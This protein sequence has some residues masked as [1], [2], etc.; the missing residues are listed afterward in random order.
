MSE[1]ETLTQRV[2]VL[3]QQV[4]VIPQI[5]KLVTQLSD[6]LTEAQ[7]K[8]ATASRIPG[9]RNNRDVDIDPKL[10]VQAYKAYHSRGERQKALQ[11][12]LN[13]PQSK[14]RGVL[15]WSEPH[16]FNYLDQ[17]ELREYYTGV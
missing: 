11:R 15:A 17:H 16:F 5:M 14:L 10:A 1:I 12:R 7:A 2:A 9:E 8:D 3:E 13:I 4:S 6:R